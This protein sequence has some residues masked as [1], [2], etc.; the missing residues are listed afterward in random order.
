MK[1]DGAVRKWEK[2]ATLCGRPQAGF[3]RQKFA[4]KY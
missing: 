2:K 1:Q 4:C 3:D